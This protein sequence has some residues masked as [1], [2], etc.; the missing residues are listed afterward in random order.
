MPSHLR[1]TLPL[2]DVFA[3]TISLHVEGAGRPNNGARQELEKP[4][5]NLQPKNQN[6][7][8]KARKF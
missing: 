5:R 3:A 2:L 8:S 6:R 1:H 7:Q 4:I